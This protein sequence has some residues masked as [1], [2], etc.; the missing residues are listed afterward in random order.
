MT[1]Q[2]NETDSLLRVKADHLSAVVRQILGGYGVH[3]Y[4]SPC[5][6]DSLPYLL[7]RLADA[8]DDYDNQKV[9]DAQNIQL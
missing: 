2:S 5:T 1:N 8:V 7:E 6:F 3:G 4:V 9:R